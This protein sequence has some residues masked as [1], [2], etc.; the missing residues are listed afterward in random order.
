M[1]NYGFTLLLFLLLN[2]SAYAQ[3]WSTDTYKYGEQYPGYV[4]NLNGKKIE[5]FVKLRNRFVMQDEV[6]FYKMHYG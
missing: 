5:G 3:D 6:I 2:S 1:K 4:I